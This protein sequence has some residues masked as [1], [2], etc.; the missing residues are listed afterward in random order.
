MKEK[1]LKTSDMTVT[2]MMTAVLCI[3]GPMTLPLPVSPVPL[4][5]ASLV[6]CFSVMILG[7]KRGTIS[8]LLY[9]LMGCIGLPVFSGFSGG[10]GKLVGP[11]GGYLIG[12]L[13]LA[14]I[15][16]FLIEKGDRKILPSFLG[17]LLGTAVLYGFGTLW[18]C[19]QMEL[20][21]LQG[22]AM[23]VLPYIPGDLLKIILTIILGR[24]IYQSVKV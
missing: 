1:R 13:F 2:A 6:I 19:L 15:G 3:L 16:G 23:G 4:S 10:L 11:T 24:K 14:L 7:W 9:L 8:V 17:L 18:L 20:S 22:L 5:L 12:Y 21:F